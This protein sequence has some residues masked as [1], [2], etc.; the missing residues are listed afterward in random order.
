[1]RE[2]SSID[3][4]LTLH[5]ATQFSFSTSSSTINGWDANSFPLGNSPLYTFTLRLDTVKHLTFLELGRECNHKVSLVVWSLK[6]CIIMRE[7]S[8]I[9]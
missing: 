5:S 7:Q 6:W 9:D 2:Q 3:L 4:L 1:M 8:S